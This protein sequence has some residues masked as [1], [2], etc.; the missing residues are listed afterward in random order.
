MS[1]NNRPRKGSLAFRPRK[2][3]KKQLPLINFWPKIS[4]PTLTGFAGYKVGMRSVSF[5]DDSSSP[6]ANSE[7]VVP[8]T[9]LEVPPLV[10]YGIR[11]FKNKQILKDQLTQDENILK[12]LKIKKPKNFQELKAEEL[13][14]V[15]VLAYTQPKLCGFGKKRIDKMMIGIGGKNVEE[16]LAYAKSILGK[17]I[18]ASQIFKEGEYFDAVAIT[19]GKGWQGA[20][21]RF[22][23][24]I[25]RRKATG[26][27]RHVGTLGTFG[28]GAVFYTTPMAGQM[29]Y[30]KRFVYNLRLLKISDQK[31][32]GLKGG[33]PHYGEVKNECLII[34]G[35]LPGPQK[36]LIRLRKAVRKLSSQI[37]TP[38][39]VVLL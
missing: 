23:V 18:K 3:A 27:R 26:K 30:H 33:Y 25:Q 19:K 38:Q 15:F 22:G 2:R 17:E 29:G 14:D 36:R 6:T 4:V 20:V 39:N 10:I 8:V 11:G 24:S 9:L 1:K 37:K 32:A 21:K 31:E 7:V 13:D 34:K 16:K 35:S 28:Y 5:I 12:T